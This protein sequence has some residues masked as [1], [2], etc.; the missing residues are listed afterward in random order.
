MPIVLIIVWK[1][2]YKAPPQGSVLTEAK[3]VVKHLLFVKGGWKRCWKGGDDFWN[4][5]KPSYIRE[6][7]VEID[8]KVVYWDDR[9]VDELRQ[10]FDA[11]K[12]FFLIPIFGLSDGGIGSTTSLMS[13]AMK[14]NGA[15]NDLMSNFNSL[16][17]VIFT[18]LINY[19][20]YPW[21][22][23]RKIRFTPMWRICVGFMLGSISMMIGAILQWRIYTE[24]ACGYEA[25]TRSSDGDS[26]CYTDISLWWQIPMIVLPAIGELFVMVTSY[27]LAYTRAPARMKG[28]IYA[29]CLFTSA[30][31]SALTLALNPILLDP[32]LIWPYVALAIASFVAGFCF[33]IFFKH[34]DKPV[35]FNDFDRME[36]KQQPNQI[37]TLHT[38]DDE[39]KA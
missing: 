1:R 13:V 24:S 26:D 8:T 34:L 35:V 23:K 36:G 3:G 9:F 16:S 4:R 11:C 17:I 12:I 19:V 21:L 7:G 38:P 15:P 10:S 14:V 5:A 37:D 30:I 31:S 29:A 33:P 27:E 28:L 39:K 32:Y 20:L 2:L 25:T 18:P 22:E 6:T